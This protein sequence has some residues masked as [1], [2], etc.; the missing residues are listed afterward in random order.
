MVNA[1]AKIAGLTMTQEEM[2]KIIEN[3]IAEIVKN[4]FHYKPLRYKLKGERRVHIMKSF[5]LKFEI[6][7]PRKIIVFLTFEHHND[8][9]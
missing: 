4:P 5:V 3:K 2:E 9:Y 7:N 8:A 6:D 1:A